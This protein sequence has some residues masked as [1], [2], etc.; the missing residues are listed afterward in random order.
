MQKS[1]IITLTL[2]FILAPTVWSV[3]CYEH[4]IK[5]QWN[6]T[7]WKD[8]FTSDSWSF[9]IQGG[10]SIDVSQEHLNISKTSDSSAITLA[11]LSTT[12]RGNGTLEFNVTFSD[13]VS[14]AGGGFVTANY[15]SGTNPC[16]GDECVLFDTAADGGSGVR[17][18][19]ENIGGTDT[20]FDFVGGQDY[21]FIIN[22]TEGGTTRGYVDADQVTT[23]HTPVPDGYVGVF[24]YPMFFVRAQNLDMH[25]HDLYYYASD[26]PEG[27]APPTPPSI[28]NNITFLGNSTNNTA[29]FQNDIVNLSINF[30]AVSSSLSGYILSWDNGTGTLINTTFKSLDDIKNANVSELKTISNET[31]TEIRYRWYANSTNGV[32]GSTG[33][34]YITVAGFNSPN[35]T[36]NSNNFFNSDNQ[37][38]IGLA[39]A[40]NVLL[41]LTFTDDVD[42]FGYEII[43]KDSD[44]NRIF[45]LTNTSL[46]GMIDYA[47]VMAN[48]VGAEGT[49]T[50]NITIDDTHT[51]NRIPDWKV[52]DGIG[53]DIIIEDEIK[54][55]AQGAIS[56][57]AIKSG[58]R[59]EFEF[60]YMPIFAPRKKIFFIES[61]YKLYYRSPSSGYKGHF[62]DHQGKR[63]IDFEGEEG[64]PIVTELSH[65][66][67]KVE[68]ENS[69]NRMHFSSIGGLNTNSFYYKY[70]LSNASL[71][72]LVETEDEFFPESFT[73]I[74]NVTGIARNLTTFRLYN[75]T[76][77]LVNTTSIEDAGSGTYFY[78]I[79]YGNLRD[80]VYKV[81]FTHQDQ[82]GTLKNS[83]T[84]TRYRIS[85]INKTINNTLGYPAINFTILDEKNNTPIKANTQIIFIY[86]G[87]DD[88]ET[89]SLDYD[90]TNNFTISILPP[91]Q[92]LTVDYTVT[93][94]ASGYPLRSSQENSLIVSNETL[95][96]TL[97]LLSSEDGIYGT[98]SV[99]DAFQNPLTN[100][101]IKYSKTGEST[102]I[103]SKNTDD[104][105]IVSF[106]LNPEQS[107]DFTITKAG[108]KT[109]TLTLTISTT[110]TRT[111]VME[112]QSE[113]QQI[114]YSTGITYFFEPKNNILNNNTNVTFRFNLTSSYWNISGCTFILKNQSQILT[115]TTCY[116]NDT[117][118]NA[119]IKFNT[120]NHTYLIA[121]ANYEINGT[122]NT[123]VS[124]QYAVL[125]T[126]ESNFTLK[127]ALDDIKAFSD[128]GFS[129]FGR[130]LIAV[131]FILLVVGSLSYANTDFREP[132]VLIPITWILVLFFSYIGWMAIP[133][134]TIPNVGPRDGWLKDYIVFI[135]ITLAGGSY[136]IRK[137]FL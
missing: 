57:N 14:Y 105:G 29:P 68:F 52:R 40:Q 111:V 128:A 76:G 28:D 48:V 88:T 36:I 104:S 130:F 5:P 89:L 35:L 107:Y 17:A 10:D 90:N 55:E 22:L 87:S 66:R 2:I 78:N 98:F 77:D 79:T 39:E 80:N 133:L 101:E 106:F 108:Y 3:A 119:T 136:L 19:S 49:Y 84:I 31:G 8:N 109:Q 137:H 61:E 82:A 56:T 43:I 45:N 33:D 65:N 116:F 42:L 44:E 127:K 70:S 85:L 41:N 47:E 99:I 50:V 38:V 120:G 110:E 25:I 23:Y 6:Q 59:I 15:S 112:P 51:K 1:I 72:Y 115:S 60:I 135:L 46:S 54:I 37:S 24:Y 123:T 18:F 129:D 126:Y 97:F 30:T 122:I 9:V 73:I 118:S 103:A 95:K 83:S 67:W 4:T 69:K 20:G 26:C 124:H 102:I 94:Q 62:V 121:S 91:N 81:N 34:L 12:N 63:W 64:N 96:R 58:D 7:F 100:T 74:T 114:S 125:W 134:D 13:T 16:N 53:N 32:W 113:G 92:Q 75:S 86:N 11:R 131:L 93:Y 27:Y 21:N 132:E 117:K 71:K